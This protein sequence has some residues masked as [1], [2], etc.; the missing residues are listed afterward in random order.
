MYSPN[1]GSHIDEC[2]CL[3]LALR[4]YNRLNPN[5]PCQVYI[6]V[7][8]G[9]KPLDLTKTAQLI[10]ETGIKFFLHSAF[11]INLMNDDL[12]TDWLIK[13]LKLGHSIG[14]SGVVVHTG[15]PKDRPLVEQTEVMRRNL[16]RA[17]NEVQSCPLLLETPAS[18]HESLHTFE[19]FRDFVEEFDQLGICV[20]T[21]HVF[22]SGYDP[23]EYLKSLPLERIKLIHF[24]DTL[25]ECGSF[26]DR[27]STPGTGLLAKRLSDIAKWGDENK[28]PMVVE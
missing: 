20:D 26:R 18:L 12:S 8:Y 11:N 28:I 5:R 27:H 7:K 21:C 14:S 9:F 13:T 6:P 15:R 3:Y 22:V 2:S 24:N 19:E 10:A 1:I 16:H 17:L 25:Q 4:N 23:L